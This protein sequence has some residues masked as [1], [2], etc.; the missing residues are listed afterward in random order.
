M[1]PKGYKPSRPVIIL[2]SVLLI[3]L[4]IYFIFLQTKRHIAFSGETKYT[5]GIITENYIQSSGRDIRY[6]YRANG[7]TIKS[8]AGYAYNSKVGEKYWVKYS[9][10]YPD[11]NEIYQNF[12]VSSCI[13]SLP[14]LG[15]AKMYNCDQYIKWKE[16]ARSQKK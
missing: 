5:I 8:D 14:P 3:A 12:P 15:F 7:I 10:E 9:V 4:F 13:D 11:I 2:S 16:R 6:I 1:V